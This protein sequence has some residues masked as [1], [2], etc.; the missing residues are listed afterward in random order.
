MPLSDSRFFTEDW[1]IT[2]PLHP[3]VKFLRLTPPRTNEQIKI[4]TNPDNQPFASPADRE[5]VWDEEGIQQ[6]KQRFHER[7]T[8]AKEKF[9]CLEI[10]VQVGGEAV[11]LGGVYEIPQVQA[12]LA[13]IGLMLVESARGRGIGKSAMQV[14]LRLSNEL[15][16]VLVHA[17]TMLA[18]KPMRALAATLGFTE[19]EELLQIPGRGVVAELLFEDIDYKRWKDLD[20][21]VEFTGPAP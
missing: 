21:N 4:L 11:G 2:V 20:M 7:Y 13:N 12:G 19:R 9:N 15:D 14:L 18:N 5:E 10:L 8:L 3:T 6:T 1:T 16:V 17:G